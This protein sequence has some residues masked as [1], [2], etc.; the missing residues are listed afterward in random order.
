MYVCNRLLYNPKAWSNAKYGFIKFHESDTSM[1]VL[2]VL[3]RIWWQYKHFCK[4][5]D[6]HDVLHGSIWHNKN[7]ML[8]HKKIPWHWKHT[9]R[10]VKTV[11]W[12]LIRIL[13]QF[14]CFGVMSDSHN[15]LHRVQ[16]TSK[17][18]YYVI[19]RFLDHENIWLDT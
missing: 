14:I 4:M 16:F 17:T 2:C 13:E 7:I 8:Y 19:N 9:V 18:E 12:S 3:T 11:L 5:A 10:H 6:S 15:V 1:T